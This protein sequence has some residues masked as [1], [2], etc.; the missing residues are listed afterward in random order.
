MWAFINE[1]PG[2]N[3]PLS[4]LL[5]FEQQQK[6]VSWLAVFGDLCRNQFFGSGSRKGVVNQCLEFGGN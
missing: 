2:T 3:V 5:P 6:T 4:N 1:T